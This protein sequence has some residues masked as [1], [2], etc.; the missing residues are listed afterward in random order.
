MLDGT[1]WKIIGIAGLIVA[2]LVTTIKVLWG[3]IHEE[4]AKTER[5]EAEIVNLHKKRV[6]EL[7][8]FKNM[9]EAREKKP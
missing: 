2:A 9:V 7:E 4:R 3:K 6:A 8:A 1:C 5:A